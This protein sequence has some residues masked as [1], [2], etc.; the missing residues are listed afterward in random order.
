MAAHLRPEPSMTFR[1][2]LLTAALLLALPVPALAGIVCPAKIEVT[3]V[4][5]A[6]QAD[7]KAGAAQLPTELAGLAVYDGPPEELAQL[8]H[9][10]EKETDKTW[11]ISWELPKNPR[12]YWITCEYA[13]TTVTLTR[14]LPETVTRCE[15]VHDRN[16]SFGGGKLVVQSMDCG[17][18]K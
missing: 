16:V 9:D 1:S 4:L 15:V 12:G 10:N 2:V 6:S 14:K 11:T 13:N 8:I 17:P 18:A 3:Q 7:W 5:T